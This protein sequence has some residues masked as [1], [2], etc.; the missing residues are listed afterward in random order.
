MSRYVLSS[1]LRLFRSSADGGGVV[2]C[3][4]RSGLSRLNGNV[5]RVQFAVAIADDRLL[6][7]AHVREARERIRREAH[8]KDGRGRIA[9]E[10]GERADGLVADEIGHRV[11]VARHRGAVAGVEPRRH[12]D[13]GIRVERRAHRRIDLPEKLMGQDHA[14]FLL[15]RLRQDDLNLRIILDVVVAFVDIDVAGETLLWRDGGALRRRLI[16]EGEKEAAEEFGAL[17]FEQSLFG[18]DEDDFAGRV[19]LGEEV[20]FR[21]RARKHPQECLVPEHRQEPRVDLFARSV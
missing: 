16:D 7:G 10:D 18:V 3:R 14:D 2:G 8:R 9:D 1:G 13:A 11:H 19:D 5:S 17:L 15:T 6:V 4:R 20:D 21:S 12:L